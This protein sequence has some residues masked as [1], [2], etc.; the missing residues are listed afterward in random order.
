MFA[1]LQNN[2]LLWNGSATEFMIYDYWV[3][4]EMNA[5]KGQILCMPWRCNHVF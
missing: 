3:D 2:I 1:N 4:G 5:H